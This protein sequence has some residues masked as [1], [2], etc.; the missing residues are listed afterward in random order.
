MKLKLTKPL[1]FFDLETTGLNIATD[2]IVEISIVKITPNGDKEIKT[3]LINPTIP[4]SAE[5]VAIHGITEDKIKDKATFKE[6]ANELNDFIKGCDLAG[7]NSN[8]FDVPLIA[9]EFLRA[10]IDFN[11]SDRKLV[12]VQNIF[13]KMEQR[14]LVAAYK[15]YCDKD[16]TNAHSAEADT[17]ATYEIL[18]AQIAKYSDLEADTD[19]LSEFSQ[20][21]KNADLLGRFVYDENNVVVFNFGKH[22]GKAI[23]EV[24]EKEP[25]YYGWMMN[26][27]FPLYTKKVMKDIKAKMKPTSKP[28]Q[29]KP[30]PNKPTYK[31]P[32][33]ANSEP[34]EDRLNMLK[35][36]FNS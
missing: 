23:T 8:R 16:L 11:V 34:T 2:R 28:L 21:T 5:S 7:F 9:E 17:T 15:F 29:H 14:T 33:K 13:H 20:M 4:I 6:V 3:K 27:D 26:G 24:L 30:K 31:K 1:A 35:N 19:F 10:G 12:D 18:E 36:K 32:N 25:G 22:K